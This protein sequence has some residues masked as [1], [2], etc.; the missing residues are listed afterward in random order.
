LVIVS[1]VVNV[2]E[3]TMNKVSVG[4]RSRVASTISV[5]S[6]LDTKWNVIVRS[7]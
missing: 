6:T 4:S 3:D 5:P 7:L 1:C 2:L